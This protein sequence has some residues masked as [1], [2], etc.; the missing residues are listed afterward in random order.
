M[1]QEFVPIFA[2][3]RPQSDDAGVVGD[4][5]G[6]TVVSGFVGIEGAEDLLE[7]PALQPG[8]KSSGNARGREKNGVRTVQPRQGPNREGI[9][10]C[11][12][13]NSFEPN[14]VVFHILLCQMSRIILSYHR[15]RT[16]LV[17]RWSITD[18]K[19]RRLV[20]DSKAE[21]LGF[22]SCD[23]SGFRSNLCPLEVSN[24]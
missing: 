23:L 7:F 15:R 16:R 19:W 2:P 17:R 8:W 24:G 18:L 4:E 1:F 13:S 11:C 22:L 6:G 10:S 21:P 9:N 12:I 20:R 5:L 3:L 14:V